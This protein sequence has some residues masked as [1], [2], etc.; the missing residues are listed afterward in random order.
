[1]SSSLIRQPAPVSVIARRTAPHVPVTC[2]SLATPQAN[3]AATRDAPQ[4]RISRSARLTQRLVCNYSKELEYAKFNKDYVNRVMLTGTCNDVELIDGPSGLY[5]R[6][7][8][9]VPQWKKAETMNYYLTIPEPLAMEASEQLSEG[10]TIYVHGSLHAETEVKPNATVLKLSVVVDTIRLAAPD[11]E[12]GTTSLPSKPLPRASTTP[13]QGGMANVDSGAAAEVVTAAAEV[14]AAASPTGPLSPEEEKWTQLFAN[15]KSFWDNR[16]KKTN[17]KAPD[18]KHKTTGDALWLN[19]RA[20]PDRAR[21]NRPKKVRQSPRVNAA[22]ANAPYYE[23]A[24][25]ANVSPAELAELE[26]IDDWV[27]LQAD[28]ELEEQ[29]HIKQFA[30][31]NAPA[32]VDWSAVNWKLVAERMVKSA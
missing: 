5:T 17:P 31:L 20:T 12:G 11:Q 10:C 15:P 21:S 22:H 8:L 7:M 3:L 9:S 29:E 14:V 26:A 23:E 18:F 32:S 2:R 6:A 16:L 24:S 27:A 25:E 19:G 13:T 30:L 4:L 28:L 1:M